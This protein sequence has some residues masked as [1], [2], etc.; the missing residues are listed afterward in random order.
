VDGMDLETHI[1]LAQRWDV[2][3][4][5]IDPQEDHTAAIEICMMMGTTLLNAIFHKRGIREEAYDQ[6]HTTR[7][8]IPP[9]AE[10]RIT[11]DVRAIM[12]DLHYVEQMRG[13]HCRGISGKLRDARD[14]PDWNPEVSMRCIAIIRNMQAFTEQVMGE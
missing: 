9:E 5:K 2:T 6:N 7:P 4:S 10:A 13:L 11:P 1:A 12:D 14:L 8:P 3:L